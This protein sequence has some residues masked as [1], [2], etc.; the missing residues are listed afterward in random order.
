[1][2]IPFVQLIASFLWYFAYINIVLAVFNMLPIPPLDG[3]K[4]LMGLLPE[5]TA[6]QLAA[7]EQYGP[8]VLIGILAIGLASKASP[9]WTLMSPLVN[10][11]VMLIP[12]QPPG[13]F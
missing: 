5:R 12:G 2:P 4:V 8:L 7:Y 13:S 3:W 11:L 6:L 1:M 10:F 9:L